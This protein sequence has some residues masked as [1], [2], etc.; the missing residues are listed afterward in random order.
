MPAR[1][2]PLPEDSRYQKDAQ[3]PQQQPDNDDLGLA[4]LAEEYDPDE[5][6][7]NLTG[8]VPIPR[9]D[10]LS[11]LLEEKTRLAVEQAPEL[12]TEEE[13]LDRSVRRFIKRVRSSSL[14][15]SFSPTF[16]D[17]GEEFSARALWPPYLLHDD[18]GRE[19]GFLDL[20]TTI[21]FAQRM[22]D[23]VVL[24]PTSRT[25]GSTHRD[26]YERTVAFDVELAAYLQESCGLHPALQEKRPLS[27]GPGEPN[28]VLKLSDS[29]EREIDVPLRVGSVLIPIQTWAKQVDKA[30]EEGDYRAMN[31]RWKRVREK[32]RTTDEHYAEEIA[33]DPQSAA[34]LK[35]QGITHLLPLFVSP[36]AEPV[37]STNP[38]Y[39]LRPLVGL[40]REEASQAVLRILT[41]YE[42]ERFLNDADEGDLVELARKI[43]RTL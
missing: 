37:P 11:E 15:R 2:D 33:D 32:L 29:S 19:V 31:R 9:S 38:R 17:S 41:A 43:G 14:Q 28:I 21:A 25:T 26:P 35:E 30:I 10:Q 7:R 34:F 20:S 39:W 8:L 12:R 40:S 23:S 22:V 24:S 3:H 27:A 42:L 13:T 18:P 36:F 16:S 4:S 6:W 1:A 5:A